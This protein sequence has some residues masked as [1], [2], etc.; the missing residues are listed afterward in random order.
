MTRGAQLLASRIGGGFGSGRFFYG[1][2][3]ERKNLR[4][5]VMV[6]LP[7]SRYTSVTP[8][9]DAVPF[10][11]VFVRAVARGFQ[12]GRIFTDDPSHPGTALVYHSCG[13]A[14]L[15]GNGA[16]KAALRLV[17]SLLLAEERLGGNRFRLYCH[18]GSWDG[19]LCA[20]LG[21]RLLRYS[22]FE[23]QGMMDPEAIVGRISSAR[24]GSVVAWTR[25]G[26]AFDE[27]SFCR[28]RDK[29]VGPPEGFTIA[30]ID[31]GLFARVS[32]TVAPKIFWESADRFQEHG[33]GFC[34]VA[35]DGGIAS[36]SF[37]AYID[38]EE[39]DVGI[40]TDPAYRGRGFAYRICRT[41]IAGCLERGLR[42]VWGCRKDNTGSRR[43]AGKLGFSEI[44]YHPTYFD[45]SYAQRSCSN[46]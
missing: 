17:V 14:L 43:L 6:E 5:P 34:L 40:E 16:E 3:A 8:L 12:N 4:R 23:S 7:L 19:K 42:P 44:M 29:T 39:V 15:C 35:P 22:D 31:A 32:G 38:G 10:D 13:A 33:F 45:V 37:S 18:P 9:V 25:V 36:T 46:P 26:F 28:G 1:R 2:A 11:R 21:G 24:D 27:K 20:A 41:M 30:P